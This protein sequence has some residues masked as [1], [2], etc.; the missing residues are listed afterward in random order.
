MR[1]TDELQ[2]PVIRDEHVTLRPFTAGD[3]G[4]VLDASTDSHIP[5]ITSVPRHADRAAAAAF[6]T[7]QHD[8]ASSG[9][10]YSFAIDADSACVGQIGLWLRDLDQGRGTIGYWVRPTSR[11]RGYAAA[12]LSALTE[13]AFSAVK[14]DRLQLYIEPWNVG[15]WRTAERVGYEREGLLRSWELVGDERRDMF[16]YGLTRSGGCS[17]A[18]ASS[19]R[20]GTQLTT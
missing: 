4:A 3:I 10:G 14:V 6:I 5:Q 15:S 13:W 16:M 1:T 19:T 18:G 8:R 20:P 9:A 11:R 17:P 2:I 7:R 12:A